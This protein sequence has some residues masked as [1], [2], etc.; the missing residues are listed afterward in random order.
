MERRLGTLE[1]IW[2]RPEKPK[3]GLSPD[4][5]ERRYLSTPALWCSLEEA[6]ESRG[7]R[8]FVEP[9]QSAE[10]AW[11]AWH[12][13]DEAERWARQ[14]RELE[15]LDALVRDLGRAAGLE[16]WVRESVAIGPMWEGESA[17]YCW[18]MFQYMFASLR[19]SLDRSRAEHAA[20][21]IETGWSAG[22]E[23]DAFL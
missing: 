1:I 19:G 9:G 12:R 13:L 14:A 3:P 23:D 17:D 6:A 21:A 4:D 8:R 15:L 2:P 5:I 20:W 18:R 11:N 7:R 22:M 16:T 10:I